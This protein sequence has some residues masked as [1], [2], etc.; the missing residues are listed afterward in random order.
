MRSRLPIQNVIDRS[1]PLEPFRQ[2]VPAVAADGV[3]DGFIEVGGEYGS[4]PGDPATWQRRL[5][6]IGSPVGGPE[7]ALALAVLGAL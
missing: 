3:L 5:P 1:T 6:F 2:R 4:L 7:A